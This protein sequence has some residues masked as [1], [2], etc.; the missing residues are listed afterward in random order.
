MTEETG[1][2]ATY[3]SEMRHLTKFKD[4]GRFDIL[5]I[6][7]FHPAYG[8]NSPFTHGSRTIITR[9]SN[10]HDLALDIPYK[11]FCVI[12]DEA[13]KRDRLKEKT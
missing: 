5:D 8:I 12:Y 6:N 10:P 3:T 11:E 4:A 13:V 1:I 7:G 2:V 9:I